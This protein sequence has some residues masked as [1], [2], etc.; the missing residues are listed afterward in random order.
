MDRWEYF[1]TMLGP[2]SSDQRAM[3]ERA[4]F[5]NALGNDGW[6]LVNVV[7]TR[8]QA[9]SRGNEHEGFF[10]GEYQNEETSNNVILFEAFFKRRRASY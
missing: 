8:E 2:S 5:L 9:H 3:A 10:G 1:S 7:A 6:E 4:N